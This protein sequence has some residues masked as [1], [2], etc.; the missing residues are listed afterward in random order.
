MTKLL[1]PQ[2][3]ADRAKC[4]RSSIMR[5]LVSGELRA[6][7][8]NGGRWH[9]DP[10]DLDDWMTMRPSDR[11]QPV[12]TKAVLEDTSQYLVVSVLDTVRAERDEARLE[13][14]S[15]RIETTQLRE[16]LDETRSERDRWRQMAERLSEVSPLPLPPSKP[17]GGFLA[18][19]LGRS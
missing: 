5:A 12:I 15:L 1:T 4:G 9:I 18:R 11:Q 7:R 13:A 10:A 6:S 17:Q 3:A 16:R 19:L 14:A 2:Q 8:N